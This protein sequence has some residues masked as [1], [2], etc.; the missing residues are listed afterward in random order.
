MKLFNYCINEE[1]LDLLSAS[2]RVKVTVL[3]IT[4]G[5]DFFFLHLA[6]GEKNY[7]TCGITFLVVFQCGNCIFCRWHGTNRESGRWDV[8]GQTLWLTDSSNWLNDKNPVPPSWTCD[9]RPLT[10]AASRCCR[11]NTSA[12]VIQQQLLDRRMPTRESVWGASLVCDDVEAPR[13]LLNT[14]VDFFSIF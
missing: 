2:S 8:T 11:D 6:P 5:V 3:S 13:C 4:S 12:V 7:K 1:W 14:H 9:L 10:V